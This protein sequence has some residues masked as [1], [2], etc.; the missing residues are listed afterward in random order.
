MTKIASTLLLLF[1]L[2]LP[3]SHAAEP[4]QETKEE[5]ATRLA[6]DRD[7]LK[8]LAGAKS[9]LSKPHMIEFHFVAR[10]EASAKALAKEGKALGYTVSE[11]DGMVDNDGKKYWFL[12][13]VQHI[14]P[15]EENV[16]THSKEMT[17]LGIKYD[18]QFD[19]W[20]ASVVK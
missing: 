7:V 15:S 11:I 2:A 12:D 8:A 4:A 13:L 20:G 10:T 6:S 16:F 9:N 3:L 19:G 1:A 14:V 5:M 17:E 18:V